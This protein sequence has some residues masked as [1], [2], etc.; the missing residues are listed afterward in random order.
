MGEETR[1]GPQPL[2]GSLVLSIALALLPLVPLSAI[3]PLS[4][5]SSELC[6]EF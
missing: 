6:P 2:P 5:P 3:T 4:L 1:G